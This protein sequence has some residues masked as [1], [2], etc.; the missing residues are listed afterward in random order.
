MV[1]LDLE[2]VFDNVDWNNLFALLRYSVFKDKDRRII[3]NLCIYENQMEA[4]QIEGH[5][6]EAII[7]K[8]VR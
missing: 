8:R 4:I 7:K 5:K 1:L 2:N 3:S 6:K